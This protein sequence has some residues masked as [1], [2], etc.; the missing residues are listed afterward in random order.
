M[1]GNL[2]Q[3][4]RSAVIWRSGSQILAQTVA[5]ASTLAVIRILDPADYGVFAMTQVVLAFL[6]FLNGYGFASSLIQERDVDARKIRQGLGLLLLVNG[7][8]ALIQ[9]GLAPFAAAYYR[10]PVV[11]DLLR[12]QALI[13]LSTPFIAL[14]EA[15][16]VREMDFRRPAIAN[17]VATVIMACVALGCALGGLGVWT[18]VWAPLTAFWVRAL[19]LVLLSRFFYLP[20]FRFKGAGRMLNYGLLMLGSHFFWTIVTQSDVFVAG[21]SLSAHQL[22]LYAEALF[23]TMIVATKFVPPLNEVAFP[24]YA[25]IQDDLPMLSASFLKAARIIM[26]VTVPL[27]FGLA[28]VAGPA[29]EVIFGPKWAG[30]AP[31]VTVLSLAMPAHT[32]HILFAPALNAIGHPWINMRSSAAGAVVMPL[33]FL[34]G[35]QWGPIGLAWAWVIAFPVI[36]A[37]TFIQAH[38]KLGVSALQVLCAVAPGVTASAVMAVPVWMIGRGLTHLPAWSA[39]AIQVA[40]G[41]FVY[42][43]ILFLFSRK[44]LLEL[45]DL[46]VRR[47]AP[48]AAPA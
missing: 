28:A 35:T 24:A 36:P 12:V 32:L 30:M 40:L 2:R 5:W 46:V 20:S 44:T 31:L 23:L 34:V 9:L 45:V 41:G 26:L 7:A 11:A 3:S 47:R 38:R 19:M 22:G 37:F 4:V 10:Q 33:A 25:R 8:I 15:L 29:V 48:E 18:L 14:P 27:Y 1:T 42:A 13:F 6:S 43:A 17:L 16:L 39:L 21:R